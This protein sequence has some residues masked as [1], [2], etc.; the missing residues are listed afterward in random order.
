MGLFDLSLA[1]KGMTAAIRFKI[2]RRHLYAF[3]RHMTA[4]KMLNF[5]AAE[6][7]RIKKS[8][9]VSSMPYVL[10][11][12]SSNICNLQCAYCYNN[13]RQPT[14]GERPYGRMSFKQFKELIDEVGDY[15]FKINLY[16]F[17]EPWLFPESLEMIK[18]ATEKNIGIGV[19]SNM[20]FNDPGLP[21]RIVASGLE[22]LIFS[23]HGVTPQTYLKF[24]RNG[25]I[26]LALRNI[27]SVVEERTRV[28]AT[29]PLIDWQYCVTGFNEHE[30]HAA[31]AKSAELGVDQIRF[32]RPFFP[33]EASDDWFS[34]MF[35]KQNLQNHIETV[36]DCSWPYRSAYVSYD[37]G[38]L[39]CCRDFRLLANDLGNVF[40]DG[41]KN[42]WNN[43]R[44]RASRRLIKKPNERVE[45]KTICA[46]CP[47]VLSRRVG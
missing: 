29:T 2:L 41:F 24:M 11:I 33:D 31:R 34:S 13:R 19:S 15:L 46:N 43:D 39:P 22:V 45:Q 3:I 5:A 47:V 21:A 32:I 9:I 27:R 17:G 4:K 40:Q 8:E 37:G 10:K 18:Y 25:N 38:L 36:L 44:Y 28:G 7:A 1:T 26:D 14:D 23:C 35:P 30:I 42:I 12:E 16:G 6:L 20:N